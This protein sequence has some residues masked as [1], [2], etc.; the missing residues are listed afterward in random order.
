ML[1]HPG[2]QPLVS[3]SFSGDLIQSHAVKYNPRVDVMVLKTWPRSFLYTFLQEVKLNFTPSECDLNFLT[4]FYW[5]DYGRRTRMPFL[6]L[7]YKQAAA[8]IRGNPS[9][10]W[11]TH[12]QVSDVRLWGNPSLCPGFCPDA[13]PFPTK[14]PVQSCSIPSGA[15]VSPHKEKKSESCLLRA[16]WGVWSGTHCLLPRLPSSCPCSFCSAHP[17]HRVA[18]HHARHTPAFGLCSWCFLGQ[19]YWY[20]LC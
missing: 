20:S 13:R 8:S 11:I 15:P 3:L 9:L 4:G 17:G 14:Q 1:L 5:T 16:H 2:V 6:R 18:L 12:P 10:P 7:G 19:E